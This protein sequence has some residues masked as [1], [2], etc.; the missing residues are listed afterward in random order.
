MECYNQGMHFHDTL[1]IQ[2]RKDQISMKNRMFRSLFL[3]VILA[4]TLLLSCSYI[5]AHAQ[6]DCIGEGCQICHVLNL[7]R[8]EGEAP[9]KVS[10][11]SLKSAEI[12]VSAENNTDLF[13]RSD[14]GIRRHSVSLIELEIRCNC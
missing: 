12:P 7:A 4:G 14:S 6:H 3:L 8:E 5:F 9:G 10:V 2:K 1:L 13:M 11:H